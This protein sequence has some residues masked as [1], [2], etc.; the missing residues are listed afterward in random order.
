GREDCLAA[1][2]H[3]PTSTVRSPAPGLAVAGTLFRG[4]VGHGLGFPPE[5]KGRAR[6][7]GR[8]R[9]TPAAK[10]TVGEVDRGHELLHPLESGAPVLQ[11]RRC[12][13]GDAPSLP[14]RSLVLPARCTAWNQRF[15]HP[16]SLQTR[17]AF[18]GTPRLLQEA[19]SG[20]PPSETRKLSLRG[21]HL[22][23][24]VRQ[25]GKLF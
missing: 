4:P 5:G 18:L 15:R 17:A 11:E 25:L 16:T 12:R 7:C 23:L 2:Q 9:T 10:V 22:S 14:G 21:S 13:H 6:G 1:Q 20:E 3:R 24:A 19:G 8:P